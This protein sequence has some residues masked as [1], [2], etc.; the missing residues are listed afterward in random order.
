MAGISA[1]AFP[2]EAD[3]SVRACLD[4]Y[5]ASCTKFSLEIKAD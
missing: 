4:A 3:H 5:T 2:G 1:V